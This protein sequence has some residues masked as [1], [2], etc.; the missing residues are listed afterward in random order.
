MTE[1]KPLLSA[2]HLMRSFG[3]NEETTVALRDVSLDLYRGQLTLIN[4]PS[5]SGKSTLLAALSGLLRP[6]SGQVTAL[7]KELW[8]I[9]EA[10]RE[11]FRLNHCGFVFQSYHLIPALTA[12][13]QLEMILRWGLGL[14]PEETYSRVMEMLSFLDLS[15]K[16]ASLPSQLSGGEKQRVAV[17]RAL[18]KSSELCFADEPTS[19]L[20]WE[21]GKQ[22]VELLRK[23]ATSRGATV[24]IVSHDARIIP[25]AHRVLRMEDGLLC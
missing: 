7:G 10:E 3:A 15:A 13:E 20:D 23:A 18:V 17:G 4:G 22:I 16:A 9:S 1:E 2:C 19:A 21:H 14:G 6:N 5:G 25:Y 11:A 12:Y 8:Q 24:V